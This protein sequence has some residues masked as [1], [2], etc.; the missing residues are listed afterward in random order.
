[1][2]RLDGALV[3]GGL[4]PLRSIRFVVHMVGGARQLSGVR[5]LD[6][7]LVGRYLLRPCANLIKESGV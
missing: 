1:V 7:F 4:T 2:R 5:R 3:R 6:G